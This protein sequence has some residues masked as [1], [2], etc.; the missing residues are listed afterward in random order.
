MGNANTFLIE[1]GDT[2]ILIDAGYP[3]HAASLLAAI[4]ATGR[5]PSQLRHLVLTHH[6]A[7]HIGSGA[8]IV[9]HT[10]ARTYMHA[11]DIAMAQTGGPFRPLQPAPGPL[12][13]VMARFFYDHD[14]RI[15]PVAVDQPISDG[16]VLPFA[17]GIEVIHVPG[18]CAGQVALLLRDK[19][20]LF[21]ADACMNIVGLGDP[22]GFEDLRAG[23][24]SQQR[25][26]AIEFD[27]AAFGHGPAITGGA[28]AR[29]RRKWGNAA[30]RESSV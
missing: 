8:A 30:L 6:H 4:Q 16:D 9:R 5:S 1:D 11:A 29:F 7:D 13:H 14:Q 21:V 23:R 25:L 27:V 22:I 2:L 3:G 20:V 18:H 10:G 26:A 12:R 15:E 17:G 28:S 24:A 19:G